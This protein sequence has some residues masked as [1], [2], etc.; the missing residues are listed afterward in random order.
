MKAFF[1]AG[2]LSCNYEDNEISIP[3]RKRGETTWSRWRRFSR[4]FVVVGFAAVCF[5]AASFVVVLF[6]IALNSRVVCG[7]V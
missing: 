1:G 6:V 4:S 3:D 7:M 2:G 5:A